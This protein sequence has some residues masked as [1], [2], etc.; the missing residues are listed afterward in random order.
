MLEELG[1]H[2]KTGSVLNNM[3]INFANE[4]K[5]DRAEQLYRQ[6]KFHFEQAGDK[7]N[8]ATTLANIADILF[9]RGDLASAD[10]LYEEAMNIEAS[11]DHS[12]PG[13]LFYR[14]A[15]LKLTQGQVQEAHHLVT[16]AV[17]SIRAKQGGYGYLTEALVEMGEVLKAEGDLQAAQKQFESG[18]D[19]E[20]KAGNQG[21]V[22][23]CE[24][25]LADVAIEQGH[26]DEAET[27]IRRAIAEFEKEKSDPASSGGYTVLSHALLVQGKVEDARQAVQ[28]ATELSLTSSDPALKLPAAI[29]HARV[30][31][32]TP[33]SSHLAAARLE[34]HSVIATARKLG[35]YA[36]ESE[37]RLV[38]GQLEMKANHGSGRSQLGTLILDAR[39]HGL[40]LVARD[41]EQAISANATMIASSKPLH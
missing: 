29:Q 33:G 7:G 8:T 26:A 40:E 32:A 9:L 18:R 12:D 4:G 25:E 13:Y 3:A 17:E 22:E 5:L 31:I 19:I 28:R 15:D 11:L 34:L 20:Q 23:E 2:Y 35:Y 27:L 24:A 1:E 14:Q 10:K 30:E 37:A 41:A 21:V 16:Q 6:A 36:I 39:R 38:L